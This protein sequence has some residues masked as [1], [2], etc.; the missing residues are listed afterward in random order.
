MKNLEADIVVIGAGSAG[1]S[2]ALSAASGGAQV[3]VLE[4]MPFP[5][6]YSLMSEGMFAAESILQTRENIGIT[7]DEAYSDHMIS[8][9]WRA[10][11]RLVRA[12]IDKSANTIDWLMQLGIEYAKVWSL[13]PGGPRT[14][15]L[16]KG[17][18]KALIQTLAQKVGEKGVKI[19]VET[20][21][22]KL[23]MDEE[24]R[25]AGV[26][27]RDK[28]GNINVKARVVII[29]GGGFASNKEMIKQAAGLSFDIQTLIEMQQTGDHIRMAWDAG[30]AHEGDNVILAIPAVPG[31]KPNS[32]LWAA[33]VQPLLWVNQLGERFCSE[34]T[35][36]QFPRMANAL[37]KQEGGLMYTIFDETSKKKL[38][39]EGIHA[40]L[41]VF[42]PATTKLDR[43]EADIKRAIEEGKFFTAD[44][45]EELAKKLSIAPGTMKATVDEYNKCCQKNHDDI[46]S[47]DP[48]Y[49]WPVKKR[50]FYAAKASYHVFTTLGGIK[51]NH[52]T[53]V[54]DENFKTIPGLY[55]AGN[56]A[57]GMYGWDYD[58]ITSGGALSFAVTSGRIA[59]ENGLKYIGK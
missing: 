57:G 55:A 32:H 24:N 39:E 33:A 7:R 37:A 20:P 31:E 59:A 58:V 23:I 25:I 27:A 19:L 21:A 46:F 41:G 9:H 49:L 15:H 56:S 40:S 34:N 51:I 30:A 18:G 50:K 4:K 42:V 35:A 47:K 13:W 16:M 26:T 52:K 14:W 45:I 8:T 36:F 43:L 29:A 6:G 54:V 44:S 17:G 53:E 1:L 12:F 3:I 5:G 22:A 11:G 48:R 28:E 10:D 2:A 38:I